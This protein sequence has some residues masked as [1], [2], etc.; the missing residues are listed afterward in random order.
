[1]H[2]NRNNSILQSYEDL[3]KYDLDLILFQYGFWFD[4]NFKSSIDKIKKGKVNV[5]E[6]DLT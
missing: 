2:E 6:L 4:Q 1:M 3:I 5:Q